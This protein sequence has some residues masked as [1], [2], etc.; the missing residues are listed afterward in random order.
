MAAPV[1]R[2]DVGASGE[3]QAH[4][5]G[6]QYVGIADASRTATHPR[7]E[8]ALAERPSH[9]VGSGSVSAMLAKLRAFMPLLGR[10]ASGCRSTHLPGC[11]I[12]LRIPPTNDSMSWRSLGG[13]TPPRLQCVFRKCSV[14]G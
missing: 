3:E 6:V 13:Y 1:S 9:T 7:R 11:D 5:S 10:Y 12:T 4:D 8:T 14:A 2:V